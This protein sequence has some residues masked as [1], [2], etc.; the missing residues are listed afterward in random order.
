MEAVLQQIN[1]TQG[2]VGCFVCNEDGIILGHALP[3]MYN[4]NSLQ[5]ASSLI[6]DSLSGMDEATGGCGSLDLRFSKYRIIVRTV[7]GGY[8]LVLCDHSIN[9][10][11]IALSLGVAQ[12]KLERTIKLL[13]ETGFPQSS[14][15]TDAVSVSPFIRVPRKDGNG[16]ILVVDSMLESSKIQWNP[17][18]EEASINEILALHLQNTSIAAPIKKLK[19]TNTVAK[20]S[21]VLN[22]RIR[23]SDPG[24]LLDDKI[25]LTLA[26]LD[27]LAVKPGDEI[28]AEFV[29]SQIYVAD[30]SVSDW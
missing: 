10:Q 2:I 17:L 25:V 9:F 7:Q 28:V 22:I 26:A 23:K 1:K 20:K 3:P 6:A 4:M 11:L 30:R 15:Q 12:K 14:K 16:V 24:Q 19:L 18:K 13:N 29:K 8:L 5:E 27:V 21:K